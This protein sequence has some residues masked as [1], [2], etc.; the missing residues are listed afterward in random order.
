MLSGVLIM[1]A[2]VRL[3]HAKREQNCSP[4]G[5]FTEQ[6]QY[7]PRQRMGLLI[8]LDAQSCQNRLR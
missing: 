5:P 8:D 3:R 6:S 4:K 1:R 2:F 7:H